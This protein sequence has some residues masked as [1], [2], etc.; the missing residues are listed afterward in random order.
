MYFLQYIKDRLPVVHPSQHIE[1]NSTSTSSNSIY[2]TSEDSDIFACQNCRIRAINSLWENINVESLNKEKDLI[3]SIM[4][5]VCLALIA[6]T[7]ASRS[8]NSI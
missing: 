2:R 3:P 5:K 4:K 6:A 8:A 1:T 7:P